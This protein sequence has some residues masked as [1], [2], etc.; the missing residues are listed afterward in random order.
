VPAGAHAPVTVMIAD[1][2]NHTGDSVFAGTLESTLKLALEGASFINAYDRTRLRDL[3]VPPMPSLDDSKAQEIAANQG[4]N[5]VIFGSLDSSNGGY[6]LS[7][8]AVQTVTGK[9]ITEAQETASNKKEILSAVGKLG[10][11]VRRALGDA[12]SEAD[13]RFSME[14]LSAASLEAVHEYAVALDDLSSGKNEDAQ[15]HFSEAASLDPNFGLAYAGLSSTA[16][17]LGQQQD[18]EKYIKQAITQIDHMTER[19][20]Y[21]TRASLYGQIGDSQKCVDE[22]G[23]LLTRYP[24]DTGAYNNMAEC[25]V[26]L[27]NMPKALEAIRRAVSILPRRATYHVNLALYSAYGG[28]FQTAAIEAAATEQLNPKYV[29]GYLAEAFADL[30]QEQIP[31]ATVVYQKIE[32]LNPSIAAAGEGDLAIYEGRFQDAVQIFQKGA[33]A[34]AAEHRP[35]AAA[36]KLESLAYAQL[37]LGH[38]PAALSAVESALDLSKAVKTRF[39]SARIYAATSETVKATALASGLSAELQTEPQAYGKLIE[40][41]L[42]LGKNDARAAVKLFTDAN[43]LLDTWIGRFDLG[44]AYV[45]IGAFT[46]A[47]SEFDRCLKRRGESLALFLDEVPTYGYFPPVYYYQGRVREGLKSEGF[48][49][50]Y[51]KYLSIR[52]GANQ[53]PLV[54]EVRR[55][56]GI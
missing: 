40:G 21:R 19:E 48:A 18:A 33:A 23:T 39:L 36:D 12:T 38:K 11:D 51:K 28:D 56:A 10:T 2:N 54:P 55:R 42:A 44:R 22:Y 32:A 7:L 3:G 4:L 24:S 14:T 31:Q 37:L 30:G 46:E 25:L 52:G 41:E 16:H 53:D 13:Q 1:F 47:D 20:R 49:D 43:T 45:E 26:E 35:D 5:A 27:R 6:E 17:N 34:D 29:Y 8:K 50:S 9:T 15:K